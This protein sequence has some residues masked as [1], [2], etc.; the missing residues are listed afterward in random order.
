[1]KLAKAVLTGITALLLLVN[2]AFAAT[3]EKAVNITGAGATFPAPVYSKWAAAYFQQ[4]G[5]KIN[6]Q[7]I[8]SSGGVNQI[9]A[10]TIDFG[11]SDA[12]LSEARLQKNNLFQFPTVIGGIVLAV[13]VRGIKSGELTLDGKTLADIYLGNI[14]FWDDPAIVALNPSVKLPHQ[15]IAVI[16]RSDGSGTTF[17][18]SS[19]LAKTSD[20]WRNSV[21]IGSNIKWPMGIGGKGNDGVSAFVQRIPGAI[22]YV[23]YAYVKQAKLNY[24]NLISADGEVVKPSRQSFSNAALDA[25]WTDSFAQDLTHQHGADVWPI[26][27]TTFILIHKQQSNVERAREVINFFNWAYDNG[28]ELTID[29]GYAPLPENVVEYV[30]HAWQSEIKDDKG[31][32]LIN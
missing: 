4:T 15:N 5:N 13:N 19:Y 26:T 7:S 12:P 28:N 2:V 18:F 14:K 32:P 23:E 10:H 8:G 16:R 17:V 3:P 27:S 29:L 21:G 6:Y 9:N 24:T 25:N 1:M 31:Q 30:R 22:G 20:E 11:A